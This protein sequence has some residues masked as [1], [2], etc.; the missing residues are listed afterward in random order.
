[1]ISYQ[2]VIQQL[3]KQLSNAKMREMISKFVR[4]LQPFEHYV[5]WC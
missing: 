5:M 1:M 2:A 4:R 3:E